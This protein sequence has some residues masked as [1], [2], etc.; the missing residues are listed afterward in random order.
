V[1]LALEK[2]ERVTTGG[3]GRGDIDGE[4]GKVTGMVAVAPTMDNLGKRC[5]GIGGIWD[6]SWKNGGIAAGVTLLSLIYLHFL[7]HVK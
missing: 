5:G 7:L 4:I 2:R 1:N 3:K 6:G